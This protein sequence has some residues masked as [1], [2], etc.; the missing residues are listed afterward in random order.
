MWSLATMHG[1]WVCELVI[2][3]VCMRECSRVQT[4]LCTLVCGCMQCCAN[5]IELPKYASL[6]SLMF[7]NEACMSLSN[8]R[9]VVGVDILP[10]W[11]ALLVM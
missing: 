1:T 3:C 9:G 6:R 8:Y 5:G 10:V 2:V 7:I 11:D 4:R